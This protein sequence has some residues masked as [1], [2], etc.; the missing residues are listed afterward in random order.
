M[1]IIP[2]LQDGLRF[3][4]IP[5]TSCQDFGELSRVATFIKS[6]RDRTVHHSTV[7]FEDGNKTPTLHYSHYRIEDEDDEYEND[8]GS[9]TQQIRKSETL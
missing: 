7:P 2:S 8:Y 6:L 4:S 1:N 5:G 3:C 9:V